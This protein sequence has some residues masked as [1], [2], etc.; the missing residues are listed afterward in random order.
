MFHHECNLK[1]ASKRGDIDDKVEFISFNRRRSLDS[2]ADIESGIRSAN[3]PRREED[4]QEWNSDKHGLQPADRHRYDEPPTHD[5][6][7]RE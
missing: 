1:A 6:R 2:D 7:I 5:Q 4:D 3:E